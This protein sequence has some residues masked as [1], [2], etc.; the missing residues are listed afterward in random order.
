MTASTSKTAV[1]T[2]SFDPVTLGHVNII[3]RSSSLFDELIIGIGVNSEK[4]SLFSLDERV[5]FLEQVTANLTNVRIETFAGLA[6]EFV[7]RCHARIMVRGVRPLTDISAEFTMMMANHHLAP[8]IETVFLMA[9]EE[10]AHVSSSLIKQIAPLSDNQMLAK[11]VPA[12]IIPDL[13]KRLSE[14]IPT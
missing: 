1:Y 3:E 8:E 10:L 9:D 13:R 2:G 14:S 7:H 12:A 4:R 6:V 11:F 5:S